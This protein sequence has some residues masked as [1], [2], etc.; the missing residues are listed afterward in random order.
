MGR[1]RP[2]RRRRNVAIAWLIIGPPPG[3]LAGF[4]GR[5]GLLGADDPH[6]FGG[7]ARCLTLLFLSLVSLVH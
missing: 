1:T 5:L 4:E 2:G 7:R 6:A 3:R